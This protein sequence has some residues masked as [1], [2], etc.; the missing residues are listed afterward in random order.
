MISRTIAAVE[1]RIPGRVPQDGWT[2]ASI[3]TSSDVL[4]ALAAVREDELTPPDELTAEV[5]TPAEVLVWA[6]CPRCSLPH[7][8]RLFVTPVLTIDVSGSQLKLKAT[9]KAAYHVCGQLSL[10]NSR[11]ADGQL[12]AFDVPVEQRP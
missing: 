2:V 4:D 7:A 1:P 6:N 8:I 12:P 11:E 3:V 10:P 9:A 5:Q